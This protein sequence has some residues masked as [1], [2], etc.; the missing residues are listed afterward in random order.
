MKI[1]YTNLV[2]LYQNVEN[3]ANSFSFKMPISPPHMW[4]GLVI[5]SVEHDTWVIIYA[6]VP[7]Y[8]SEHIQPK[9]N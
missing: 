9:S 6:L 7:Y 4:R 1:N 8:N 3:G 5:L 2:G